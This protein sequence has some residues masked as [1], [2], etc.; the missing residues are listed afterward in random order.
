[1]SSQSGSEVNFERKVNKTKKSK[2][3]TVAERKNRRSH[4]K[5][6]HADSS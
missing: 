1:M 5:N 6:T 2:V 3:E 4:R